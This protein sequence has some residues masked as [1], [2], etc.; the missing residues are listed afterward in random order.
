MNNQN[1]QNHSEAVSIEDIDQLKNFMFVSLISAD[2]S[3]YSE[4]VKQEVLH[5]YN[6]CKNAD[7]TDWEY[8]LEPLGEDAEGYI[9][10][11][12]D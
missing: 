4:D 2:N 10:I 3:G 8:I 9:N 7:C 11:L 12:N 6:V 5:R 1:T